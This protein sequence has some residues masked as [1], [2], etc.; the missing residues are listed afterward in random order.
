L[1]LNDLVVVYIDVY[2]KNAW[3]NNFTEMYIYNVFQI[4]MNSH[5]RA[6]LV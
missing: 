1:K 3:I 5:V 6:L 4:N 2:N